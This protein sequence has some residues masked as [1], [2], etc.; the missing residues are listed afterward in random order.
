MNLPLLSNTKSNEALSAQGERKRWSVLKVCGT[1]LL[2]R[3][4]GIFQ[5]IKR[6]I[7]PLRSPAKQVRSS[8][9][10]FLLGQDRTITKSDRSNLEFLSPADEL[11]MSPPSPI[12][13]G[14]SSAIAMLF[15]VGLAIMCICSID[16]YA[17]AQGR[18]QP[19]GRSKVIQPLY[20]GTVR[21]IYVQNGAVVK[22][23]DTLVALDPT[24][25]TADSD[26]ANMRLGALTAEIARRKAALDAIRANQ[27]QKSPE[28]TF[29]AGVNAYL[30]TRERQ[31][32]EADFGRLV[33]SLALLQAKLEENTAQRRSLTATIASHKQVM[34]VL[35]S[36]LNMRS[37]LE[38]DGWE[39]HASVLDAEETL[40]REQATIRSEEGDLIQSIAAAT[41]LRRQ[42]AETVAEFR[43]TY[44][45]DLD[46]AEKDRDDSEQQAV[47][48]HSKVDYTKMVAPVDGSVQQ[49]AVTT[50]GQVVS[51]GQQLM[52]VVPKH[53]QLEVLT[54]IEN[55][56]IGFVELGQPVVIKIDA[57]PFTRYGTISG[58]VTKIS[59]D[60]VE[61]S[62]I[63]AQSDTD[64][65]PIQGDSGV[66]A[67]VPKVQNLVYPVTVA[68][69]S[70]T[71][72]VDGKPSSIVPGMSATVEIKTGRERVIQYILSPILT[73]T[74]EAMHER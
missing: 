34:S 68:L 53:A 48:A 17:V 4:G 70:T 26:A 58:K 19:A 24:E 22:A 60:A 62:E 46:K 69:D 15:T 51:P 16:I 40:N 1:F 74:S 11:T 27:V 13:L 32:L 35:T 30:E 49:V 14:L 59:R 21:T 7:G 20:S 6:L 73:V 41:T 50:I 42:K 8:V 36:R 12:R 45:Q 38:R 39:S 52:I 44:M 31:V 25:A 72:M 71:L 66:A 47:K 29:P 65:K 57:Y 10:T 67:Q 55:K 54:L 3:L 37:N 9:L 23:G 28:I 61:D 43:S 5:H 64:P 33:A 2:H 56:D 63:Q 18:V